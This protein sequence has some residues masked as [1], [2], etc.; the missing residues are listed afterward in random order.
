[1]K[2]DKLYLEGVVD[3]MII[4]REW[5]TS[6]ISADKDLEVFF[7]DVYSSN[8]NTNTAI[9]CDI[10]FVWTVKKS[11]QWNIEHERKDNRLRV[12]N[13]EKLESVCYDIL[14]ILDDID[15]DNFEII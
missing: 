2:I 11:S 14:T 4:S 9:G 10:T 6:H 15:N 3:A 1:M 8:G 7:D 13:R 5:S 12:F